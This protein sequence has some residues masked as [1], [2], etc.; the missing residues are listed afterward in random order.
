MEARAVTKSAATPAFQRN[1][2]GVENQQQVLGFMEDVQPE[3]GQ[4]RNHFPQR[5]VIG[6]VVGSGVRN[7][8]KDNDRGVERAVPPVK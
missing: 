6:C 2:R 8:Q 4:A 3:I 1:T 5:G 7:K